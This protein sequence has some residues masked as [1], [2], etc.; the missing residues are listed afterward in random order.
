MRERW[1]EVEFESKVAGFGKAKV[2]VQATSDSHACTKAE[3][4]MTKFWALPCARPINPEEVPN[5]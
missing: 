3:I 4:M 1:F 2:Q 5:G